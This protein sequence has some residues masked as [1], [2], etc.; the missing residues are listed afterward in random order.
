MLQS[1][2]NTDICPNIML[3]GIKWSIYISSFNMLQLK[4]TAKPILSCCLWMHSSIYVKW[5]EMINTNCVV[6]VASGI[7]KRRIEMYVLVKE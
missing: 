1:R 7:G 2:E 3:Q 6:L 4:N 5:N